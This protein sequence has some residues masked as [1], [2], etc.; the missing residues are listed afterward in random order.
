MDTLLTILY[1]YLGIGFVY[2]IYIWLFAGDSWYAIPFNIIGGPIIF[3]YHTIRS[4]A[5][6]VPRVNEIFDGKKA[7]IFDL[8]GTIINSQPAR[9]QA[10]EKVL[11]SIDAAWAFRD[12]P[13]GLNEVEKW[14]YLLKKEKDIKTDLSAEDLAARTR[15]AYLK[16]HTNV[17]AIDG[18]WEFFAYLREEKKYK[19]GLATNSVRKVVDIILE[20]LD[21]EDL[22]D[23]VITGDEVKKRKPH[24][25][26]YKTAAKSLGVT[27]SEVV[28]FEDTVVGA[29]AAA[30]SRNDGPSGTD[31]PHER[32]T[33][34][35]PRAGRVTA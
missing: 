23:F 33:P 17:T 22:F 10:M 11:E 20:R 15:E 9:N 5:R 29:T 14:K 34:A 25:Q 18:F 19:V 32:V 8:D 31:A 27:P 13:P 1:V 12:Y 28:V 3:I 30:D 4:F 2:A 6:K 21:A 16:L 35:W 24:P 7:V 26:I